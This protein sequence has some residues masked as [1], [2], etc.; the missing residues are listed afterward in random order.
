MPRSEWASWVQAIGVLV[1]LVVA[2]GVPQLQRWSQRRAA[3]QAAE[4]FADTLLLVAKAGVDLPR[5]QDMDVARTAVIHLRHAQDVGAA[6]D[7]GLLPRESLVAVRGLRGIA[8]MMELHFSKLIEKPAE[9]NA[10]AHVADQNLKVVQRYTDL[11]NG[12]PKSA[13][14]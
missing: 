10:F 12:R 14:F 3:W 1:A 5:L 13:D 11:M 7:L 9:I 2:I 8:A 4:H 6:L